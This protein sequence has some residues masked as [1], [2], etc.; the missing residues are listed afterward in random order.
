MKQRYSQRP[1]DTSL[2]V[3]NAVTGGSCVIHFC[4]N[5]TEL[6]REEA[7]NEGQMQ[8]VTEYEADE[9]SIGTG[10]RTGLLD[11]VKANR[12]IWLKAAQEAETAEKNVTLNERVK[13]LETMTEDLA[14][15]VLG[16]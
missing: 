3:L 8:T 15:A 6:T 14:I 1:E 11:T 16:M 13:T 9:Y 7:D 5:I 4:E 10:Y 2:E 12:E